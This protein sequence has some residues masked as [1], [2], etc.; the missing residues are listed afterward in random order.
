MAHGKSLHSIANLPCLKRITPNKRFGE[1][2]HNSLLLIKS[3][4]MRLMYTQVSQSFSNSI[5][6]SFLTPFFFHYISLP[7]N[8]TFFFFFHLFIPYQRLLFTF[9]SRHSQKCL[10]TPNSIIKIHIATITKVHKSHP[11][12]QHPPVPKEFII[13]HIKHKLRKKQIN[14]MG[15]NCNTNYIPHPTQKYPFSWKASSKKAF[16]LILL[17]STIQCCCSAS[18]L[19]IICIRI[20]P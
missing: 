2:N 17:L 4:L 5:T 7:S 16:L 8:L 10:L 14:L 13:Q 15:S 18:R 11:E 6:Y 1:L 12:F 20:T 19:R 9:M 3:C